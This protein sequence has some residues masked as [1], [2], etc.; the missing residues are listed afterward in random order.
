MLSITRR[1]CNREV[2]RIGA[3]D[4]GLHKA[5]A[6][7]ARRVNKG[8]GATR[9][10]PKG[11]VQDK[12]YAEL[13]HWLMIGLFLPGEPIT[14]RHLAHELGV[15]PMPVRAALRHLIAE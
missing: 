8:N 13:R 15:S 9:Q 2:T 4:A 10:R 1:S 7:S 12:V 3:M 14:L 11:D 6:S 5:S